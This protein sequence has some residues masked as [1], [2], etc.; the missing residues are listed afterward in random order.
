M[1]F[2]IKYTALPSLCARIDN[3]FPLPC[4]LASLSRYFCAYLFPLRKS[5]GKRTQGL[6][7]NKEED[8]P[9]AIETLYEKDVGL[10]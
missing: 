8:S 6:L 2:N 7:D 1:F 4:L 5:L 3:A 9:K 10:V